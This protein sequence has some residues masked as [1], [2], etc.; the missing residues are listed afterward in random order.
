MEQQPTG[1]CPI[2][3]DPYSP[4]TVNNPYPEYS[5]L[6]KV[7][8]PIYSEKLG[9]WVVTR[10]DDAQQVLGDGVAFSSAVLTEPVNTLTPAVM[11][12]LKDT[13][14][15]TP[16]AVGSDGE[17]HRRL[18]H[19]YNVVFSPRRSRQ[20]SSF[21][22]GVVDS[23]IERLK[24]RGAA[25]IVGELFTPVTIEVILRAMGIGS[26]NIES[27]RIWSEH[28]VTFFFRR[29]PEPELLEAATGLVTL[30]QFL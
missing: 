30:Y 3:F 17:R 14:K 28:L 5:R 26:E 20:F 18:R 6:R 8:A 11:E 12:I 27:A 9:Y 16:P 23:H 19:P 7:G 22:D 21:V 25:E 4:E 15:I 13:Y 24:N 1:R 29:V 10:Y 2:D